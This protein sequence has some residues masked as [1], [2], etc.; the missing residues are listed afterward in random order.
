[1]PLL[2]KRYR[3]RLDGSNEHYL[4]YVPGVKRERYPLLVLLHGFGGDEN[5]MIGEFVT[6]LAEK[7]G[8]ALLSPRGRGNTFYDGV[9]ED[10]VVE[11]LRRARRLLPIDDDRVFLMGVSMGGTGAWRLATRCP[12][13]FAA[14]VPICG[15]ADWRLWYR[16]WYAPE[17]ARNST[18]AWRLPLLVRA[19]ALPFAE[20]LLNL[21]ILAM[22]GGKD[23]V[24]S[25]DES[26]RMFRRLRQLGAP[27][28][29]KEYARSYHSGFG[30]RWKAIF[31]WFEGAKLVSWLERPLDT[32]R[33]GGALTRVRLPRRVVYA[34]NSVNYSGAYWVR[35]TQLEAEHTMA[36]IEAERDGSTVRVRVRGIRGFRIALPD[37]SR[38]VVSGRRLPVRSGSAAVEFRLG[39]KGWEEG[40]AI[41]SGLEKTAGL[42]G[43]IADAFRKPFVIVPGECASDRRDAECLRSL[44]R[45]WLVPPGSAASPPLK[46]PS[47][48]TG[49]DLARTLVLV[50]SAETNSLVRRLRSRLP[51]TAEGGGARLGGRFFAGAGL[52]AIYPSPLAA[53]A[54]VLLVHRLP[55]IRAKD[56]EGLPWLL[57][58]FVVFA[59]GRE[60]SRTVHPQAR[61][62]YEALER[63]E[64][65][66]PDP[67]DFPPVYLPDCFLEAG[68]FGERWELPSY[69]C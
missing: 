68:F 61:Q 10:D 35:I 67:L 17:A 21:P 29:Y 44:W 45:R 50:G 9:G 46:R 4:L 42:A 51:F 25:P 48:L 6:D 69:L 1:V 66:P 59:P 14:A 63:K 37:L 47:A 30:S 41:H 60:C 33:A 28:V 62:F 40:D 54:Y 5:S 2:R 31:N 22:H 12:D 49:D 65:E 23:S 53:A 16:T 18:P 32:F 39:A 3:S 13:L 7:Y 19:S 43:P 56:L 11:T 27:V 20:N 36:R 34:T 24:V 38:I 58:D 8:Y 64:I 57:P 26:R 55:P 15:W 52:W